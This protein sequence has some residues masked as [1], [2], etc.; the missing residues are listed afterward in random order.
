MTK[1]WQI[2]VPYGSKLRVTRTS[3]Y[4]LVTEQEQPKTKQTKK[5]EKKKKKEENS[6]Y[7]VR[8]QIGECSVKNVRRMDY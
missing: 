2:P 6:S 5:K 4:I 3:Y 8:K 7:L 1:W